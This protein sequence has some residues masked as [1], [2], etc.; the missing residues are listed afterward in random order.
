MNS[1]GSDTLDSN[2]K[3]N[4]IINCTVLEKHTS[5]INMQQTNFILQKISE[6][7]ISMD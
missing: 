4:K 6:T 2:V 5:I 1:V 7:L 3:L